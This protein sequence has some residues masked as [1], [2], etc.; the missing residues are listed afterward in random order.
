M[1]AWAA[2]PEAAPGQQKSPRPQEASWLPLTP[3]LL[4]MFPQPQLALGS[5]A[6]YLSEL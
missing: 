1:P 4:Q 2:A 3:V 5:A 6:A